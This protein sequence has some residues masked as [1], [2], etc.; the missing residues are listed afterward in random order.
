MLQPAHAHHVHVRAG[1]PE[2]LHASAAVA[3][4]KG[5]PDRTAGL[6]DR[7]EPWWRRGA[8]ECRRE[9][10]LAAPGARPLSHGVRL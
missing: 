10:A 4:A 1:T 3:A 7:P 8:T 9:L 2:A 6:A 5:D